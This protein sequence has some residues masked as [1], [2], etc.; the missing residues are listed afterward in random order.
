MTLAKKNNARKIINCTYQI[1]DSTRFCVAMIYN[2]KNGFNM[3]DKFI[4]KRS[5]TV[6]VHATWWNNIVYFDNNSI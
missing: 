6:F 1:D 4:M 3:A 2:G 5:R